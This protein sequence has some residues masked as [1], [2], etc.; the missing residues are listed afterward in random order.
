M[1][2]EVKK[3][4]AEMLKK[5]PESIQKEFAEELPVN[6][7]NLEQ[8]PEILADKMLEDDLSEHFSNGCND[9]SGLSYKSDPAGVL[10]DSYGGEENWEVCVPILV[11]WI[12]KKPLSQKNRDKI[13]QLLE[14]YEEYHETS[15]VSDDYFTGLK[16]NYVA[17]GL[18]PS[19]ILDFVKLV[20]AILYD[21]DSMLDWIEDK[22]NV[23]QDSMNKKIYHDWVHFIEK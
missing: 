16:G 18:E 20:L 23:E 3:Q 12:S 14:D 13:S 6:Y 11:L 22:L 19:E 5:L 9:F 8:L 1:L 21:P 10:C 2:S 7:D 4:M 15:D 17:E